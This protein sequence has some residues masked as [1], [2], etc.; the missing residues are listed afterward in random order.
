M[1]DLQSWARR[2]GG[3]PLEVLAEKRPPSP[4]HALRDMDRYIAKLNVKY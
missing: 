3:I 2:N 4:T 1:G